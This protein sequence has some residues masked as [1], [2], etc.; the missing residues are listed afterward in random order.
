MSPM[1]TLAS[2]LKG[3]GLEWMS[4]L[5]NDIGAYK[6]GEEQS[7]FILFTDGEEFYWRLKRFRS[8]GRDCITN[9]PRH[10]DLNDS[11]ARGAGVWAE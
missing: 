3:R 10:I 9:I 7:L 4:G 5:P 1:D 8:F 11:L 6:Q 2:I